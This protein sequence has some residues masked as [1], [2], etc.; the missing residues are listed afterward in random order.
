MKNLD[1]NSHK[2]I[3]LTE[4]LLAAMIVGERVLVDGVY[5][6][7]PKELESKAVDMIEKKWVKE[8]GLD[9]EAKE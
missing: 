6:S 2:E 7:F 1:S 3:V 8:Y 5:L 4:T 9:G